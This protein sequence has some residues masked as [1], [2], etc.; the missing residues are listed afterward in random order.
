MFNFADIKQDLTII[1]AFLRVT[2]D[3]IDVPQS[4]APKKERMEVIV[5]FLNELFRHRKVESFFEWTEENDDIEKTINWDYFEEYLSDVELSAFRS[6]CRIAYYLPHEPFY[7]LIEGYKWDIEEKPIRNEL[8]LMEYS[9]YIA[10]SVA[11]LCTFTF[12]HRSNQWPDKFGPACQ[13]MIDNARKM[14]MVSIK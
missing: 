11:T 14:G 2:D 6:L 4:A 10:S 13:S 8:D 5:K 3:M 1:Y 7:E 12:C 9:K